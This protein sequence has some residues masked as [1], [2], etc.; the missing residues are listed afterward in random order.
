MKKNEERVNA[1][2]SNRAA[3]KP[4]KSKKTSDEEEVNKPNDY[5]LL[6]TI[7]SIDH[8]KKRI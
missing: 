3:I 4:V 7:K 2:N 1:R 8:G 6:F 5:N